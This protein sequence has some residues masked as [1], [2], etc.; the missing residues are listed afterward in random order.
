MKKMLINLVLALAIGIPSIVLTGTMTKPLWAQATTLI[1]TTTQPVTWNT[2]SSVSVT[3]A[4]TSLLIAANPYRKGLIIQN[5]S[6]LYNVYIDNYSPVTATSGL[7]LYPGNN[8]TLTGAVPGGAW[9]G[10]GSSSVA[11]IVQVKDAQ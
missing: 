9:Y 11:A 5:T 10:L 8:L 6:T 1:T 7:I 3:N 2:T 4:G